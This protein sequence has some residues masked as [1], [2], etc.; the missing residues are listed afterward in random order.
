[1]AE[2]TLALRSV[3]TRTISWGDDDAVL[4]W[5]QARFSA[6]ARREFP[7]AEVAAQKQAW[8]GSALGVG[9]LKELGLG[10]G[11]LLVLVVI[12]A[13]RLVRLGKLAVELPP[14]LLGPPELLDRGGEVE[15]VH[16][17]DGGTRAQIGVPDEGVQLPSGLGE[18]AVDRAQAFTLLGG[19]AAVVGQAGLLGEC[20][21][22]V[23]QRSL[24]GTSSP[25][26]R[27]SARGAALG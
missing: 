5:L 17:N 6:I 16:G 21:L 18:A 25:V 23:R 10:V 3:R 8:E 27:T 9:D 7:T 11:P 15:E 20:G 26:S 24:K 14:L 13:G 4:R 22:E 1:V 2:A 12:V 19:V